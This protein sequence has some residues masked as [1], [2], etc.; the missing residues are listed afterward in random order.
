MATLTETKTAADRPQAEAAQDAAQPGARVRLAQGESLLSELASAGG[1]TFVLTTRRVV[2]LG[3]GDGDTVRSSARLGDI[4]SVTLTRLP[5]DRRPLVWA[6]LGFVASIGVWQVISSRQVGVLAGLIVAA[7]SAG[8]VADY[9]FRPAGLMLEFRTAGGTMSGPIRPKAFQQADEFLTAVEDLR[10]H[11]DE[12][13][14]VAA[15]AAVAAT[16]AMTRP[17]HPPI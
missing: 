2:Y 6:V 7:V 17:P 14:A 5:R 10:N 4:T 3:H 9:W 13:G 16:A 1:G 8:L 12:K 15:P 11:S